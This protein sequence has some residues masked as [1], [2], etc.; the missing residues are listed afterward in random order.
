MEII[1]GPG[2]KGYKRMKRVFINPFSKW[3][4]RWLHPDWGHALGTIPFRK[5]KLISETRI[6]PFGEE[7]EW[8]A[9]YAQRKLQER[10]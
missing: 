6:V 4:Y 7:K 10:H 2:D 1:K 9:L 8:L 5:N 3:L